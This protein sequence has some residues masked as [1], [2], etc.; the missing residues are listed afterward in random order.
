GNARSNS[1]NTENTQPAKVAW[2]KRSWSRWMAQ[3]SFFVIKN[4]RWDVL[5]IDNPNQ[6]YFP[7]DLTWDW[8]SN[9][10]GSYAPPGDVG[11]SAYVQ[12]KTGAKGARTNIFRAADS[13]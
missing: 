13:D 8:G 6:E 12:S 11:L 3:S 7:K 9:V 10:S 4:N 5:N 2:T 1:P